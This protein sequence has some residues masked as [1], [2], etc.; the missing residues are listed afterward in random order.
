VKRPISKANIRDDIDTQIAD[1]LDNGGAIAEVDR[2]ISGRVNPNG[3]LKP[4]NSAFQ[5]PKVGRTYVPEVIAAIDERRNAKPATKPTT[6]PRTKK[7]I[8]YDDFGEPLRWIW[9]EE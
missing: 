9:V 5:Q 4:D 6:K 7:K 1:F 2:G 8:I 3:P